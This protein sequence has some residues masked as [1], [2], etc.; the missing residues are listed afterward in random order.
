MVLA[1]LLGLVLLAAAEIYVIVTIAHLIGALPTAALLILS[2]IGGLWLVRIE[3]RRAWDALREALGRGVMPD[4]ELADAAV[5]LASGVLIAIPGFITDVLGLFAAAP[6]TRPAVR[7]LLT[8]WVT[9]RSG[10]AGLQMTPPPRRRAGN[11]QDEPG[12]G[13]GRVVQGEVLDEHTGG[14]AHGEADGT[15]QERDR[16]G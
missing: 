8:R 2:T 5:I 15:R 16:A 3:R 12:P 9:R 1:A 7:V 6:V 4:R 14:P 10:M 11:S 13:G